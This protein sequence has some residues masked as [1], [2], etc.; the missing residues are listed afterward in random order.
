MAQL[1]SCP[2]LTVLSK[3]PRTT[4]DGLLTVPVILLFANEL[5][6]RLD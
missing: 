2:D 5:L 3:L 6:A 4:R 1:N